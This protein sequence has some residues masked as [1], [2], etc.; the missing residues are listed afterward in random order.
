MPGGSFTQ[1]ALKLG[2]RSAAQ[3]HYRV[4][5]P[6]M[7]F[8]LAFVP[9]SPHGPHRQQVQKFLGRTGGHQQHPVRFG[10]SGSQF[11]Y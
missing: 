8:A 2:A 9:H 7:Q 11:G 3:I 10:V 5:T 4:D 1:D 6:L